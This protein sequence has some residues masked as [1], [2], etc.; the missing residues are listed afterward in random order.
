[1]TVRVLEAAAAYFAVVFAAGFVLGVMRTLWLVPRL[2][3]RWAEL[4]EAP[5]MLLVIA[6][7]ARTMVRRCRGLTDR[8][9]WLAAGLTALALLLAVEFTVVLWVR[10]LSLS[11]YFAGRDPVASAVYV[12]LLSAFALLPA[13]VFRARST[14]REG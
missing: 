2:G 13:L 9:A 5:V 11:Q 1:M 14:R 10:G 8:Q 12:A 7:C 3:V 4:A 6:V